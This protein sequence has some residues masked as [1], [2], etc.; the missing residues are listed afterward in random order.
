MFEAGQIVLLRKYNNLCFYPE[1]K[2]VQCFHNI[3]AYSIMYNNDVKFNTTRNFFSDELF[4][5]L[6]T[7]SF[8]NNFTFTE[9]HTVITFNDDP[10][11]ANNYR[12]TY[13]TIYLLSSISGEILCL[14]ETT[15]SWFLDL[16]CLLP[17]S[18]R[19]TCHIKWSTALV[20]IT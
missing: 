8:Q 10:E 5:V 7:L 18:K 14:I 1:P 12:V 20:P 19:G 13:S 11:S 17:N 3:N 16:D 15:N 2:P 4:V 6:P 9:T